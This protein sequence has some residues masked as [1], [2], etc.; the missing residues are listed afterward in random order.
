MTDR[1]EIEKLREENPFKFN[2]YMW[3]LAPLSVVVSVFAAVL[4]KNEDMENFWVLPFAYGILLFLLSFFYQRLNSPAFTII[5]I[6][7]F[8]RYVFTIFITMLADVYYGLTIHP[9]NFNK[10]LYLMLYEMF[11]VFIVQFFFARYRFKGR[12]DEDNYA[13]VHGT[14]A[15]VFFI[16]IFVTALAIV[17]YPQARQSLLNF[18]FSKAF[19]YE[20]SEL[21]NGFVFV[22]FKIGINIIYALLIL[23]LT[24]KIRNHKILSFIL[25]SILTI[26][27]ISC[28]W[29]TGN[30][31]SRWGLLTSSFVGYVVLTRSFPKYK[32]AILSIGGVGFILILIISSVTKQMIHD[33]QTFSEAISNIFS[34]EYFNEYFQGAYPVSNGLTSMDSFASRINFVTFLDD[35]IS[36]YPWINRIFY[37]AGNTTEEFY[38]SYIGMRDKILPTIVQGYAHFGIVGSPIFSMLFT[39]L[40]Y[41]SHFKVRATQ[42]IFYTVAVTQI[43][44]WCA[45]FMAVNAYIIQRT[46]VYFVLLLLILILDQKIKW[47]VVKNQ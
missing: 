16:T 3:I 21:M 37:E 6:I 8:I 46:T 20:V 18:S 5:N 28:N 44:V 19:T 47:R 36:S 4:C 30:T 45:L 11:A 12:S 2:I 15:V 41:I 34:A 32:N 40:A 38:L 33:T 35:T 7:M 29:T 31:I 9:T 27:F 14:V 22:F 26:V 1:Y 42:N 10:A 25:C 17:I 43:E 13:E 24:K 39:A 23:L